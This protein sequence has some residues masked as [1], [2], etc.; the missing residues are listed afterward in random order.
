[1]SKPNQN[2]PE[3][4]QPVVE[5][6]AGGADTGRV[7]FSDEDGAKCSIQISS[8]AVFENEDG[9]V[10]DP[11]GWIWLGIDDAKPRM[12]LNEKQVRWLIKHL[13]LWLETGNLSPKNEAD[14]EQ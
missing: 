8:R 14:V 13:T 6:F 4:P 7:E 12:H 2:D 10:D 9:T 3:S 5:S 11:L 1:M